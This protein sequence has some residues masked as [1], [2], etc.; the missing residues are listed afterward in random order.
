MQHFAALERRERM[1]S[2]FSLLSAAGTVAFAIH[3]G[4]SSPPLGLLLLLLVGVTQAPVLLRRARLRKLVRSGDLGAVLE[5]YHPTIEQ[6]P[7][8]ETLGPLMVAAALAAHGMIARARR[9]LD[10]AA[11]GE[12]WEAALEQRRFVETL[13]EAFDG[14]RDRALEHAE[15]IERLPLPIASASLRKRIVALRAALSA[16]T[17]A[18]ARKSGAGD[19]EL[20]EA[21]AEQSPLVHWAMRY[22]AVVAYLERGDTSRARALLEHAPAWPSDSAFRA[23]QEELTALSQGGPT[24]VE[25]AP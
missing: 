20:L 21:A 17:R 4:F 1:R 5:A 14:D 19:A 8:P 24:G 15:S 3:I 13:L 6:L 25:A 10:R 11:R 22:G 18:F 2:A 16:L 23:F 9:A 7:H 12:A